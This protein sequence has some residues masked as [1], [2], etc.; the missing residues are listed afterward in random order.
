[1]PIV[2]NTVNKLVY[3]NP[4][5]YIQYQKDLTNC[6]E[7]MYKLLL[8]SLDSLYNIRYTFLHDRDIDN[9]QTQLH[10]FH[11]YQKPIFQ[12]IKGKFVLPNPNFYILN[13]MEVKYLILKF[14]IFH[15]SGHSPCNMLNKNHQKYPKFD[16]NH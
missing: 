9:R 7:N 12:S 2:R 3:P 10:I 11:L 16:N 1:M 6:L 14:H 8:Y 15:L 5:A 4:I 13:Q